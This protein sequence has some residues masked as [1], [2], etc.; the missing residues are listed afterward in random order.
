LT[1]LSGGFR[2]A[3][4]NI[5]NGGHCTRNVFVPATESVCLNG[6]SATANGCEDDL[7]VELD[8]CDLE[9]QMDP[10]NSTV[11]E[12]WITDVEAVWAA[13]KEPGCYDACTGKRTQARSQFDCENA[14]IHNGNTW[15][16]AAPSACLYT[17]EAPEFVLH[18]NH[19]N[20]SNHDMEELCEVQ[21]SAYRYGGFIVDFRSMG[22]ETV[23]TGG[24]D[25]DAAAVAL[26]LEAG[27]VLLGESPGCSDIITD[28]KGCDDPQPCGSPRANSIP[29]G[30]RIM[31]ACPETC[32]PAIEAALEEEQ[33][34]VAEEDMRYHGSIIVDKR[35][36]SAL[37]FDGVVPL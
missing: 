19:S 25:D 29:C 34:A 28:F 6:T 15:R 27:V 16:A 36:N 22:M 14:Y 35:N 2:P 21:M 1:A 12:E 24:V 9:L 3:Q 32:A 11:C 20:I 23:A 13:D 30:V 26:A 7:S 10:W 33:D 31:Q 37:D 4:S 17:G 18:S 5:C 8:S